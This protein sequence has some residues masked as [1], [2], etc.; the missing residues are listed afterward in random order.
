MVSYSEEKLYLFSDT[1]PNIPQHDV[2]SHVLS[3]LPIYAQTPIVAKI[4]VPIRNTAVV[5][6][7]SNGPQR[8][9]DDFAPYTLLWTLR[10]IFVGQPSLGGYNFQPT[11]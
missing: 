1:S 8:D 10:A 2:G 4:V 6:D 9:I 3:E 5:S 11:P 7:T